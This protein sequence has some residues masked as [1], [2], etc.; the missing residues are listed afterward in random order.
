MKLPASAKGSNPL[1]DDWYA[2]GRLLRLAGNRAYLR[3]AFGIARCHPLDARVSAGSG[4]V[5][6]LAH[7]WAFSAAFSLVI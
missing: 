2:S 7:P 4:L 5:S 3:D 1:R 6:L